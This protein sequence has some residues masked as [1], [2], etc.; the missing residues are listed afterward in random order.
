VESNTSAET[1]LVDL[2]LHSNGGARRVLRGTANAVGVAI[3]CAAAFYASVAWAGPEK[4]D[5]ASTV[6]EFERMGSPA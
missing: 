5:G 2:A 6:A 4:R 3:A 1:F